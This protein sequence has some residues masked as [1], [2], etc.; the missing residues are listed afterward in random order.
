MHMNKE[1]VLK[2]RIRDLAEMAYQRDIVTFTDFLDLNEQNMIVS[3]P[4]GQAGV[5]TRLWGGYELAERRITAFIPDALS[6]DWEYPLTCLEI[7]PLDTRFQGLP[8]HRDFL[9]SLMNL[10]IERSM[11]GDLI[12]G[13]DC[14]WIYCLSHMSAYI[15]ENLTR[16]KHSSVSVQDLGMYQ[17]KAAKEF[18]TIC[19][20]VASVR[21][22]VLLK[23]AFGCARSMA[24][25]LIGGGKVFVNG[26]LVTSNGY[27]PKAGDIISARGMGKFQYIGELSTT[28]KGRLQIQINKYI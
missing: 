26:K 16:V 9:G 15:C 19:G 8:G 23:I 20:T 3:L 21:L 24:N 5:S 27:T 11:L 18:K 13:E 17:P 4:N 25:E 1:D 14:A 7:R 6:Y 2:K 10:G 28:K 12:V 22:D